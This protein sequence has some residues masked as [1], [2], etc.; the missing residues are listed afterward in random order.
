MVESSDDYNS[1]V[2][3]IKRVLADFFKQ[4]LPGIVKS[5]L[6]ENWEMKEA[7]RDER[8]NIKRRIRSQKEKWESEQRKL[9]ENRKQDFKKPN[10]IFYD[11]EFDIIDDEDL[12]WD[13]HRTMWN[14]N[15]LKTNG[16]YPLTIYKDSWPFH[17]EQ[18]NIG[19]CWLIAPLMTI[20][21]RQKLLEWILPP[22]DYSLKHGIFL[23]RLFF[24]GEWNMVVVD[25]HLPCNELG[26]IEFAKM[27]YTELW[28]CIIEK[29]VAKMLGGYHKLDGGSPIS[30][31]KCLTGSSSMIIKLSKKTDLDLLWKKLKEFQCHGFLMTVD[32]EHE[33][34]NEKQKTGL[35][36][37][38]AYSIL[39]TKIHEG[40]R[41]ILI[42]CPNGL[43]WK[44]K[45][46]E[47]DVYET[48][49][50]WSDWRKNAVKRRLSWMEIDDFC[51]WYDALTV[52]KY[53]EDWYEKGTDW[54]KEKDSRILCFNVKTRCEITIEIVCQH[55]ENLF[56]GLFEHHF[57][58]INIHKATRDN[59][60]GEL[61]FSHAVGY[62]WSEKNTNVAFA[63][64]EP[65]NFEPG[66]YLAIFT[67]AE[68]TRYIAH[69]WIF[70]SAHRMENISYDYVTIS[71]SSNHS[72]LRMVEKLGTTEA[73]IR[74]GLIFREYRTSSFL[75]VMAENQ[76]EKSIDVHLK[77]RDKGYTIRNRKW[78]R[79]I[80]VA[81]LLVAIFTATAVILF[82]VYAAKYKRFDNSYSSFG[83]GGHERPVWTVMD[84]LALTEKAGSKIT[85]RDPASYPIVM[86]F[87][88]KVPRS[89]VIYIH[90]PSVEILPEHCIPI[91]CWLSHAY[92]NIR[93]TIVTI[94]RDLPVVDSFREP[95][96]PKYRPILQSASIQRGTLIG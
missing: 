89:L 21:R 63:E 18:G 48:T 17:A 53:R 2:E 20:A 11:G 73:E 47:L 78:F 9:Q 60:I 79:F 29:A 41:L 56:N 87:I 65:F 59:R 84:A 7:V 58:L 85:S 92:Y 33:F 72:L 83:D 95:D 77:V 14:Y 1:S 15:A 61:L 54:F 52:C 75:V 32:S 43:K 36:S 88:V 91:Y 49:K 25:G 42:G 55:N 28:G 51:Q 40:H 37:N 39:D 19:D 45:W 74:K 26:D 30:A 13:K 5:I 80:A 23:V 3:N 31:F 82:A 67:F 68:D 93:V 35:E 44:G 38:H 57:G 16:Q 6:V 70:R 81:S 64:T 90:R 34:E 27:F 62:K 24:H 66:S 10:E 4:E 12:E 8:R 76:T 22:N 50:N 71:Q 96:R 94:Y 46:S 86:C 69:K